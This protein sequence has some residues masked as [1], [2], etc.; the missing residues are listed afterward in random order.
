[1]EVESPTKITKK[2]VKYIPNISNDEFGGVARFPRVS[3][4]WKFEGKQ[5]DINWS[6]VGSVN[7]AEAKEFVKEMEAAIKFAGE[8]IEKIVK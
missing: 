8:K 6:T 2:T 3:V 4:F 1:M 5:V 7:V